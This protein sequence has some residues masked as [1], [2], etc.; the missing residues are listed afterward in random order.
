MTPEHGIL[1][2][3]HVPPALRGLMA[4]IAAA[5]VALA[6]RIARNGL[7]ETLGAAA[8][9]NS[10]G[11]A[12]KALDVIA[13]ELF[14]QAARRGGVRHYASEEQ[15]EVVVL[16]EEA[17]FA[18]AIDPL[19]G[20]SNIDT[21]VAIGTIFSVY[22]AAETPEASFLRPVRE[23]IG[24]GYVIYGPQTALV[25]SFGAGVQRYV[26]DAAQGRFVLTEAQV[27]VPLESSEFAVNA[28][29]YRHWQAPVR[30]YVDDCVAGAEGPRAKNFNMRWIASLVAEVHRILSRGGVFL[31]PA[32]SRKGY[33]NGRLRLVYECAPIA[34]LMVQAGGGAT[35]GTDPILRAR[36]AAL[37]QRTPFVF[38]SLS[39]VARVAAYHDMPAGET[40]ALFGKRGL[41]RS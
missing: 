7:D 20:S 9:I 3:D 41:F 32:D 38:G 5:S 2:V 19:D 31:Y 29:N 18:L 4:E 17:P 15:E 11:D 39:K 13:D 26:L 33:E 35:D 24:A 34:F 1:P 21:N 40:A 14:L 8:G 28:S 10:D 25:C 30:A 12:Q 36:P 37:H 16:R 22:P 27:Q 23:Q 6:T